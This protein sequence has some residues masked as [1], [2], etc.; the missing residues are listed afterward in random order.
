MTTIM[1]FAL[2]LRRMS[3][4]PRVLMLA[5]RLGGEVTYVAAADGRL[6]MVVRAPNHAAHRFAP[7]LRRIVDVLDVNELHMVAA[8][9]GENA[10]PGTRRR[11]LA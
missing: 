4:L 11:K 7:Q 2:V 5:A 9:R 1:T 8:T 10:Q 6:N 3:A